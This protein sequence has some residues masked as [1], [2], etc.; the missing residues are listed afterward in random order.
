MILLIDAGNT[1]IKWALYEN[2]KITF[3]GAKDHR[4]LDLSELYTAMWSQ[5]EKPE[6]ILC[7]NVAGKKMASSLREW[8]HMR[9]D[10]SVE[11]IR[12]GAVNNN[13]TNAYKAPATLGVD[14]WLNLLAVGKASQK[15]FCVID[16]GSF[17]TIDVVASSG[18]HQGGYITT[19]MDMMYAA[20]ANFTD[21]R[22]YVNEN[23]SASDLKLGQSTRDCIVNG[24]SRMLVS[25]MNTV[26]QDANDT[27]G[28]MDFVITGGNADI[29]LPF[30]NHPC[31][32]R[33]ALIFEGLALYAE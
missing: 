12:S 15:A 29:F 19:G 23:E 3:G 24:A 31:H 4:C 8:F 21:K 7:S 25:F 1:R 13:L 18:Q 30:L 33:P 20:L 14:R 32:H 6:K 9:W 10:L 2:N 27:F 11:F 26:M 28:E 17:V 16:C 22:L 5:L